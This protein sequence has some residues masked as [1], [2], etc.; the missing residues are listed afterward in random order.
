MS[1]TIRLDSDALRAIVEEMLASNLSQFIRCVDAPYDIGDNWHVI[2][3]MVNQEL[4]VV[5]I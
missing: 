4:V 3:D 5:F 2:W 1:Y